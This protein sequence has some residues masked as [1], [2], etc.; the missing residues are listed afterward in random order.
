[1]RNS[2]LIEKYSHV[3]KESIDSGYDK[4]LG[5][6]ATLIAKAT[7]DS[8]EGKDLSSA[9]NELLMALLNSSDNGVKTAA[10]NILNKNS[11][12]AQPSTQPPTPQQA[13][14][15]DEAIGSNDLNTV[16]GTGY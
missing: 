1:M 6:L 2:V 7:T 14:E 12:Q 11:Q 13:N 4:L 10:A 9:F 15:E 3:F 5:D 16:T 8:V